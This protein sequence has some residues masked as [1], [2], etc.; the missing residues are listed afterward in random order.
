MLIRPGPQ[1]EQLDSFDRE[2]HS[3][4]SLGRQFLC[5]L[6]RNL[7]AQRRQ[8]LGQLCR[9]VGK[10]EDL[11]LRDGRVADDNVPVSHDAQAAGSHNL[12]RISYCLLQSNLLF[13]NNITHKGTVVALLHPE[14]GS[15]KYCRTS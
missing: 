14:R 3:G 10:R 6:P 7:G 8:R 5:H 11:C 9:R 13:G 12:G 4:K 1:L 15:Y 2:H